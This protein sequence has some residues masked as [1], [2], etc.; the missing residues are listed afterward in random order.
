ML[1]MGGR[2]AHMEVSSPHG[3]GEILVMDG[4]VCAASADRSRATLLRQLVAAADVS[5]TDLAGAL[6]AGD[7]VRALV[8]SGCVERGFAHTVAVEQIVDAL[9]EMLTWGEGGF[10]VRVGAE[11]AGDIGVRLPMDEAIGRGRGR[12]DEWL[13]VRAALP[14]E[15]EVLALV[16]STGDTVSLGRDD[17]SVLVR[18]DGRRTLGEVVAA[19]GCAPLVASDRVVD[20]M[21]RG[22][23]RVR[24]EAADRP[25]EVAQLLDS[26]EEPDAAKSAPALDAAR[27]LDLP[28]ASAQPVAV[29]PGLDE[30]AGAVEAADLGAVGA[31]DAVEDVAMESDEPVGLAPFDGDAADDLQVVG[32]AGALAADPDVLGPSGAAPEPVEEPEPVPALMTVDEPGMWEPVV[33]QPTGSSLLD[34]VGPVA[35]EHDEVAEISAEP[36]LAYAALAPEV[37]AGDD[38]EADGGFRFPV[39][40]EAEP[41]AWAAEPEAWDLAA[42]ESGPQQPGVAGAVEWSPWAQALGLGAPA[43]EGELVADPL[44]GPGIAEMIA[45]AHGAVDTE[46]VPVPLAPAFEDGPAVAA[47]DPEPPF[48]ISQPEPLTA[49]A[50]PEPRVSA[51][52]EAV[53]PG[54]EPEAGPFAAEA[55]GAA[56]PPL[57]EPVVEATADPLSGGL[58]AQLMSGVRGL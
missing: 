52:A 15:H 10:T 46:L 9:G 5:A 26:V 8:D 50:L 57:A 25:D 41:V 20:L 51:E 53:A 37:A 31:D 38:T 45:G 22:L 16:Q 55:E 29:D 36:G 6:E 18:V 54:L 23:V 49:A 27:E 19:A 24:T 21:G 58:L 39:E 48:A 34:V 11:P 7:A 3:A 35:A 56:V 32:E 44:A 47:V 42:E 13:R 28:I 33:E 30:L 1:A 17:W 43:P 40:V 4:Q 12:A 2:S 14:G